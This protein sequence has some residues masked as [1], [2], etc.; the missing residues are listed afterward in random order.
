M[1]FINRAPDG[2]TLNSVTAIN[3]KTLSNDTANVISSTIPPFVIG[4]TNK[5]AIRLKGGNVGDLEHVI[6]Q[7][8]RVST[9]E[10]L[11]AIVWVNITE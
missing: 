1:D 2:I 6:I 4:G 9:G 10:K 11:Q 5:V 7:V 8:T 3:S